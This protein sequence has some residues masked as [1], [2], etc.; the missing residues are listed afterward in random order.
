MDSSYKT[1]LEESVSFQKEILPG[2]SRTFALTIPYLPDNLVG[3]VTNAY[4]LCRMADTIED[5]REL[6]VEDKFSY[7][8][9]LLLAVAKQNNVN[10]FVSELYPRLSKHTPKAEAELIKNMHQVT[11]YT[12]HL[13]PEEREAIY[14]C[15]SIMCRG[16]QE[17][18][19]QICGEGF[20]SITNTI[21]YCYYVAGCVGEMLTDLFCLHSSTIGENKLAL[22]KLAISFGQGLQFTNILKDVWADEVCSFRFL[23]KHYYL[24]KSEM[25]GLSD[26]TSHYVK[27]TEDNLVEAC[28]YGFLIPESEA[29]IRLFL[30]LNIAFAI[31]TLKRIK[32]HA[33]KIYMQ[34]Q[35]KVPRGEVAVICEQVRDSICN[36]KQLVQCLNR[37]YSDDKTS[38]VFTVC[39]LDEAV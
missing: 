15:L 2:V 13:V 3:T 1:R 4:L 28:R 8:S 16:M 22:R 7:H 29:K 39:L 17:F 30:F 34:N 27:I 32:R 12:W 9:N 11:M 37:Y 14:R 23:P 18:N 21:S 33:G 36:N 26:L 35:V 38:N 19:G 31:A 25:K 10:D 20:E 6:A 24:Q 5:D